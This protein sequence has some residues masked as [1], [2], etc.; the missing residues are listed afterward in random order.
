VINANAERQAARAK[1]IDNA[2]V[3]ESDFEAYPL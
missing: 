1:D 3:C 2:K